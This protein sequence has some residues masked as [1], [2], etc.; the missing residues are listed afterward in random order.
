[1]FH[2]I[3]PECGREIP[4][5]VKECPA[6]DPL[7]VVPATPAEEAPTEESPAETAAAG[8]ATPEPQ[9]DPLPALLLVLA[10]EVRAVQQAEPV[11]VSVTAP[12]P[13]LEEKVRAVEQAEPVAV[14]V[15]AP[16]PVPEDEV[17]AVQQAEPVA[18]SVMAPEPVPEERHNTDLTSTSQPFHVPFGAFTDEFAASGEP[19]PFAPLDDPAGL[20]ELADAVGTVGAV[21]EIVEPTISE[22]SVSEPTIS[23]T[24]VSEPTVSEPTVSEPTVSDPTVSEPAPEPV[25]EAPVRVA[26]AAPVPVAPAIA[27]PAAPIALLAAPA[28]EAVAPPVETSTPID[29]PPSESRLALA[30]LQ[31]YSLAAGRAMQPAPPRANILMPDSGPRVTLPGPALPP[32]LSSFRD[33]NLVAVPDETPPPPKSQVAGWLMSFLVTVV[34]LVSAIVVLSYLLPHPATDAKSAPLDAAAASVAS[35]PLSRY[36]EVTGFRIVVDFNKKSEIHYLVVNHSSAE[37]DG[38]TVF[39]TLWNANSKPGQPPL[40]RFSFRASGLGPFESKE[41]TSSIEKLS[42]SVALP[43]WQDLRADV[44]IGR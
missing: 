22:T 29:D 36:V 8:N 18:V 13:V 42:R 41:M 15:T 28:E 12:E 30:P 39:V 6:C 21:E 20:L 9:P 17:R 27:A 16:E 4:P 37:L 40:C 19:A 11:A 5:S 10:E 31:D 7:A 32:Q 3:C 43:E 23:E 38:V 26:E 44:Q 1:M 34:L 25:Q 2:W 24:S 33:A 14:S 35:H